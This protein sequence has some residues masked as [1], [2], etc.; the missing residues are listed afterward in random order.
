MNPQEEARAIQKALEPWILRLV[1][2]ATRN[3]VR[4]KTV[5][6]ATPANGTTMGGREPYN[7]AV[8]NLP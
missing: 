3:C 1:E 7:S 4:R 6:V 8:M 2:Q 5:T